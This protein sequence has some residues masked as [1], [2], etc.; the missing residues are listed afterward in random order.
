[1]SGPSDEHGGSR[2]SRQNG[3]SAYRRPR[4][5]GPRRPDVPR[6]P[7][8]SSGV[9]LHPAAAASRPEHRP[10]TPTGAP[11][12]ILMYHAVSHSP[13]PA[14]YGLSVTPDSFAAQ[15]EVIEELGRTPVTTARLAEAWRGGRPLPRDPVLLT[16]DDGYEGVHRHA[17]PALARHGFTASLFVSTGWLPGRHHAGGALDTMLDW[18]QVREL[19]AYGVEIGGHSHTH[20]QLDQLTA[21]RLRFE[22]SH[23]RELLAEETGRAPSS[24]A[25]PFGYSTRRV[26]EAVRAC[27]FA[28]SLAVN[29]RLAAPR[30]GPYALT[31]LTVRRSTSLAEFRRLLQGRSL[32]LDFTAD[33]VLGKGYAAVRAV[34]RTLRAAGLRPPVDAGGPGEEG[35]GTR[36]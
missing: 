6:R 21:R 8:S 11:L 2:R 14:T 15:L 19:A 12:P 31:R 29:N 27:G 25:Y 20:P 10:H 4:A 16:F 32:A 35:H 7:P 1:M 26:R 28:Q 36:G 34:N 9:R 33:R 17:L 24:F 5:P 30:Q 13:A 18:A 23:C 3:D 22:L